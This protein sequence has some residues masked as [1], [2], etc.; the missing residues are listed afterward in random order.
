MGNI[1]RASVALPHQEGAAE[2]TKT[3]TLWDSVHGGSTGRMFKHLIFRLRYY[4]GRLET[5]K[6]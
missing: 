5:G 3:F 2:T 4:F 1:Y 6:E